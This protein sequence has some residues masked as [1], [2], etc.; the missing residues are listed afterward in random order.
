MNLISNVTY[1]YNALG[2]L[3]SGTLLTIQKNF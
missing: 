3:F 1:S 2:Q